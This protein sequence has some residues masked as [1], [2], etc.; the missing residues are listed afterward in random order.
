[1]AS[2]LEHYVNHVRTLS[3]AGKK[4]YLVCQFVFYITT[5]YILGNYRELTEYLNVSIELLSKNSNILEN[6]LETLDIQQHSL[7]VLY[8]LVAKFSDASVNE[9]LKLI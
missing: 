3:A 8:V 1:M 7:G 6:V 4:E 9:S 2:A 5:F